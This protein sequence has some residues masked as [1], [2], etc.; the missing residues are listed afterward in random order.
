VTRDR[1]AA[2][3]R[4][5]T[6]LAA[7]VGLV[8]AGV[9]TADYAV[10]RWRTPGAEARVAELQIQVRRDASA[11]ALL[12]AELDQVTGARLA[13]RA[14]TGELAIV[15]IA[16]SAAFVAC[17][18]WRIALGPRRPMAP[19]APP[20]KAIRLRKLQDALI[21]YRITDACTGCTLCA[22]A[23]RTGAIAYRPYET[24]EIVDERC[25]WCDKCVEV[26]Q[27]GAIEVVWSET[28]LPAPRPVRPRPLAP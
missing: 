3:A 6:I 27:E 25:T 16:A 10:E 2:A 15:L 9:M 19:P 20:R 26:C 22:Q 23:C 1:Q 14:R 21:R 4:V 13:R 5:G 18:K 17:A 24:H 12:A 11:T 7:V 28:G 8:S